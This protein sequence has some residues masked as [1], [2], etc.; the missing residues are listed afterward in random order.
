MYVTEGGDYVCP[1]SLPGEAA[2][3]RVEARPAV[4]PKSGTRWAGPV[5]RGV[6][7]FAAGR[8]VGNLLFGGAPKPTQMQPVPPGTSPVEQAAAYFQSRQGS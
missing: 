2:V 6:L 4:L 7:G 1:S 5:V 3:H 8:V